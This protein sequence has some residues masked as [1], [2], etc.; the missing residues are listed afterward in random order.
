MEVW[1]KRRQENGPKAEQ[2]KT[3]RSTGLGRRT[4]YRGDIE[5]CDG[6]DSG[7]GETEENPVFLPGVIMQ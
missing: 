5:K 6:T 4:Q 1:S 3:K 7:S 2:D